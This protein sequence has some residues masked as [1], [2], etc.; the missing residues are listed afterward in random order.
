MSQFGTSG[1]G[2]IAGKK[3]FEQKTTPR[4]NKHKSDAQTNCHCYAY[5]AASYFGDHLH[6]DSGLLHKICL[7]QR[8][9]IG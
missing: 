3:S 4:R 6:R 1:I 9:Y 5:R 2:D 7:R 8:L